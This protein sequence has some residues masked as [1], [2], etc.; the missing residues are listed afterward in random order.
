MAKGYKRS[1]AKNCLSIEYYVIRNKHNP[2]L[3]YKSKKNH[4]GLAGW[5]RGI[6]AATIFRHRIYPEKI[7][8]KFGRANA[9]VVVVHGTL[10]TFQY[11][12]GF[13]IKNIKTGKYIKPV[14]DYKKGILWT[15]LITNSRVWL[16]KGR[17]DKI[18]REITRYYP[19]QGDEISIIKVQ[20]FYEQI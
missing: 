2:Q 7:V 9:E 10:K 13:I 1:L 14:R 11:T 4:R 3:F 8:S 16:S 5:V 18:V 15:N 19:E 20:I 12:N 6:K 17:C